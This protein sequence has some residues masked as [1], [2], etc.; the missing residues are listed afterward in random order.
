MVIKNKSRK[1][2]IYLDISAKFLH[3]IKDAIYQSVKISNLF[4][5]T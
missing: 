2:L 3:K 4:K 5:E 1:V